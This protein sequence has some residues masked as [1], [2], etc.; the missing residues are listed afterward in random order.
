[1]PPLTPYQQLEQEFRRFAALRGAAN[2]L[3]WDAAVMMPRDA[4]DVRGDQ[5]AALETECHGILVSPRVARLIERADA[6]AQGLE[7]WQRA[8]L[9]EMRR[10]RDRAIATPA[11]LIARLARA[12]A[13]AEARW[14]E[15]RSANDYAILAP[16]LEE[17]MT[18]VRDRSGLVGAALGLEPYD[19]LVDECSPGLRTTE[20]EPLFRSLARRL[21]AL[22]QRAIH[23]QPAVPLVPAGRF[24]VSRQRQLAIEILRSLG[25]A[26]EHGRFDASERP[27]TGG[28]RGDVRITARFDATD[29][30]C[31][32]FAVL[33]EAGHAL[34]D[35]GLPVA[36][37]GQPVGRDRGVAMQEGQS[38][39][40]ERVIG[41][42]APFVAWLAP[43]LR[44][45]YNVSGEHWESAALLQRLTRV[46][47]GLIRVDADELTYLVHVMLRCALERRLLAGELRVADL[48]EAWNAEVEAR[49]AIRPRDDRAGVLQDVHWAIGAF[50]YFPCSALGALLAAQLHEALR[51]ALPTLDQDLEAGRFED[52][53][54]WL[55]T[56]IYQH[57]AQLSFDELVRSAT[58]RPLSAT[59]WLRYVD[60]KYLG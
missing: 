1:M 7:D 60:S 10:E 42:S 23:A 17:V 2:M 11:V 12:S 45:G 48:P 59:P 56:E 58:G 24:S 34:Y 51:R 16:H 38:S 26:L 33:H 53:V 13:R 57:G 3:R 21:P 43:L 18:L 5:L 14:V 36:W 27:F 54:G 22:I 44:R 20:I 41:R 50:G 40:L 46:H 28:V 55:R 8:N 9:R 15:A 37:R 19:A 32:L 47:R 25:F 4:A 52:L 39:L 35:Q 30:L 6:N 49:L 31:G 29:P